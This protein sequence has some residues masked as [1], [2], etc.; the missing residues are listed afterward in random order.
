MRDHQS[1]L[2]REYEES[3][4]RSEVRDALKTAL[5]AQAHAL[6]A[7]LPGAPGEAQLLQALAG[8]PAPRAYSTAPPKREAA[9]YRLCGPVAVIEIFGAL[10][11]RTYADWAGWVQGYQD[12][13]NQ[14]AAAL[15][16][17][18][19]KAV[20]LSI[21]SPGG[22]VDGCAQLAEQIRAAR[23]AKPIHACINDFGT[24][25]AYWIA[26]AA[27]KISATKTARIGS[28]GVR[29]MHIDMSK[30]LSDAGYT[31][32]EIFAGDH[33][34]DGTP[35]APLSDAARAAIQASIDYYHGLFASTVAANR[36]LDK[37]AVIAT[38]AA[39]YD[40]IQA[41]R[42][43]LI[44]AIEDPDTA[45]SRLAQRYGGRAQPQRAAAR[46]SRSSA[47]TDDPSRYQA[48][49]PLI[50]QAQVDTASAEGR[51][52]GVA[53]GRKQER[54]RLAAVLALPEAEGREAQA[55]ALA[56][57]TDLDPTACAAILSAA[58]KAEAAPVA[59]PAAQSE[60]AA[61][62]AAIGNPK[63]GPDGAAASSPDKAERAW[64]YAFG[65]HQPVRK[66]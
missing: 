12:V 38:Q 15:G 33:K 34:I 45:I 7:M 20:A 27:D 29:A 6:L 51:Q 16:D 32:T 49:G 47:M 60:F 28:I 41:K 5:V 63:I 44:D 17:R 13:A 42:L 10:A 31:V 57:T 61:H 58:P 52:A 8:L 53:E 59:A 30:A 9:G 64:A 19:V 14:L 50:T 1:V 54:D 23:G 56:L 11:H 37:S 48:D 40:P 62:M 4:M 65:Q 26:S 25:A 36:G 24:S 22:V 2:A 18:A 43:G 46:V 39:V 66:Q 55:K 21:D 35:Y 3:E